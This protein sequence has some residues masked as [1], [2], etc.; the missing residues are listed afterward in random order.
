MTHTPLVRDSF[1]L[2]AVAAFLS[3]A[4]VAGFAQDQVAGK[5]SL[6][7][8]SPQGATTAALTLAVDGE[9]VKGSLAGDMGET[10][11]AGK[12]NGSEVTFSFDFSGPNGVMTI[13]GKATVSGSEMKGEMD[14][15]MGVAPFTGKR[16]E[17]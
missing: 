7:I 4:T 6:S 2:L 5:W 11:V 12:V 3:A 1:R 17:Q 16:A 9:A 13:A 14:Y 10:P 8:D 15:G